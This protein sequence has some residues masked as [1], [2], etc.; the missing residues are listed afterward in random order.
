MLG[1]IS[2][3]VKN[4]ADCEYRVPAASGGEMPRGGETC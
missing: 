3:N 1:P 4:N 2:G